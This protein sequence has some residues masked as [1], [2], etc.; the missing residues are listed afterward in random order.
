MFL[1]KVQERR[2]GEA[3]R[4]RSCPAGHSLASDRVQH[5]Q[6]P[7]AVTGARLGQRCGDRDRDLDGVGL[8]GLSVLPGDGI[9]DPSP[10]TPGPERIDGHRL[11]PLSP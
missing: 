9:G 10:A 3:E 7:G 2:W 11:G 4:S 5:E 8:H 1:G 6:H